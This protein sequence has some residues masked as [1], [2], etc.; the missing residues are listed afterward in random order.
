MS[1][2]GPF[3]CVRRVQHSKSIT[4]I[5]YLKMPKKEAIS[6]MQERYRPHNPTPL[7]IKVN[8][9]FHYIRSRGKVPELEEYP[10][11]LTTCPWSAWP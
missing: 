5:E 2:Q 6:A 3:L 4:T 8:E 10:T 11:K 9:K 1:N 7:Q